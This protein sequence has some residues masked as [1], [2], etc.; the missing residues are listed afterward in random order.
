MLKIK[1][2]FLT[3]LSFTNCQGQEKKIENNKINLKVNYNITNR[4]EPTTKEILQL[5]EDFLSKDSLSNPYKQ[6]ILD[7]WI[8]SNQVPKPNNFL[9]LLRDIKKNT[10]RSTETVVS[11]VPIGKDT[12]S[13]KTIFSYSLVNENKIQLEFDNILTVYV[14]KTNK[15]FKFISSP[16]WYLNQWEVQEVGKI[17]YCFPK[18]HE[19]NKN[20]GLKL[21]SFN[22]KI[23]DL[24]NLQ[25][26][27][28]TY[29]IG[30]NV[31]D[32]YQIMGFDFVPEAHTPN[33]L[34]AIC[35]TYNKCIFV[36]NGSEYYPHEVV[37]LYTKEFWGK[38]GF[39][40]HSWFDE[41]IA[42]LFGGS[43]GYPLE[44]HL[45]KL[46]LFLEQ[47]PQEILEDISK[48]TTVP[49]GEYMTE[50]NYAIGGLICKRIYESRGMEG[51]FDL[52]KSGTTDDDF[53]KAIEKHFGVKKADFGTFIRNELKKIYKK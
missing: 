29:F 16:Q 43:R 4:N 5:W 31:M 44:W 41:G 38:D 9:S 42:T 34:G 24:F 6:D 14:V 15:G 48:L 11:L 12:F 23:S 17:H 26:L 45:E 53:Y 36:G 13:L 2:L 18:S 8:K 47:N 39:Y 10:E 22:K 27:S 20:N 35:N 21:D 32:A 28:F 25:S 51:L 1:L 3:I 40:Y 50:Y 7:F 52:L 33:Q 19:F 37:H 46:K 30:K 49:N